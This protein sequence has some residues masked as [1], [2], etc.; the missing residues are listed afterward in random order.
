MNS[1]VTRSLASSLFAIAFLTSAGCTIE[2][3]DNTVCGEGTI[4]VGNT[5]IAS[6]ESPDAGSSADINTSDTGTSTPDAGNSDTT[7][8]DSGSEE[9]TV[10]APDADDDVVVPL[11]PPTTLPFTVD[12]YYVPSGFM[13]DGESPGGVTVVDNAC[14]GARAGEGMGVCREFTWNRGTVGWAGV[15]WQYP[16]SNW[17]TLPGLPVPSGATEITFYAWG[18]TGGERVKFITGIP[19]ADGFNTE[20]EFFDLALTPNQYTL[21]LSD[22][23]VGEEVTGAFGWVVDTGD[24]VSFFVDDI[25]WR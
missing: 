25:Q 1:P 15:Y 13:G 14:D 24:T 3:V 4:R 5:C 10:A 19:D 9:D 11:E 16:D 17:G 21:S 23:T 18:A 6:G 22:Q 12:D 20:T 8:A 7:A 2:E